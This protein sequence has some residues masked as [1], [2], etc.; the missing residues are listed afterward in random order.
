MKDAKVL[1]PLDAAMK[2]KI[3]RTKYE[4]DSLAHN[5]CWTPVVHLRI[6]SYSEN[7]VRK[8]RRE[9]RNRISPRKIETIVKETLGAFSTFS[10]WSGEE[11][12]LVPTHLLCY[13]FF[14]FSFNFFHFGEGT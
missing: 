6:G 9:I 4:K 7:R 8:R 1:H 10:G 12:K 14:C 11:H 2:I 3:K 5:L 13:Q